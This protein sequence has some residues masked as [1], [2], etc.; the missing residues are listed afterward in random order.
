MRWMAAT[1][2][3]ALNGFLKK[4]W[5]TPPAASPRRYAGL[6]SVGRIAQGKHHCLRSAIGHRLH[7]ARLTCRER[8][9][10]AARP[11]QAAEVFADVTRSAEQPRTFARS[12]VDVRIRHLSAW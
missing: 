6:C 2:R 1:R 10:C 8:Y 12:V 9:P 4:A 3:T 7:V 11:Q 5:A